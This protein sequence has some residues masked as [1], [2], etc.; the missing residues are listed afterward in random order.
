MIGGLPDSTA[1]AIAEMIL[2]TI[3]LTAAISVL[4]A[5]GAGT[6]L[7]LARRSPPGGRKLLHWFALLLGL[8]T[9]APPVFVMLAWRR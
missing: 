7:V 8:A 4:C 5:L 9:L 2:H 6:C 3:E 1:R